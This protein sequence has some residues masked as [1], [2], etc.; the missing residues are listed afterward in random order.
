MK[1]YHFN[2]LNQ[3]YSPVSSAISIAKHE[4]AFAEPLHGHDYYEIEYVYEGRGVQV[5]NDTPYPVETGCI[6]LFNITD[7]HS[8]Y[9]LKD[10]SVYNCCFKSKN[11]LH[12]FSFNSLSSPVI[13]LDSYF[14]LQVEQL[15][16]LLETELKVKKPQ[17]QDVAWSLLELILFSIFRND[18]AQVLSSAF[19]SPLL[20]NIASKYKTITL[21]D[22]ADI[23]GI[24]IRH[25]C[26]LFKQDYNCTFHEYIK[27][28]RIQQ[29]KH[30]LLFTD[31][32][33]SEILGAVGYGNA[34]SFFQDF[35]QIVG[36]TP[37]QYRSQMKKISVNTSVHTEKTAI[38][39]AEE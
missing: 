19:W 23:M 3:F 37:L 2:E 9:S 14:Q 17:Y 6:M 8:Y 12:N 10:M 15:F 11:F 27:A 21:A 39:P 1:I 36:V 33:V 20:T 35:K 16:H 4:V 30:Q 31:K 13:R 7:V 28:I 38:S 24:S 32:N 26:R 5:I 34:C 18:T 25:F 29:A 22:A